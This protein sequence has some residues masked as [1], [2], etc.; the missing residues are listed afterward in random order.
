MKSVTFSFNSLP[1]QWQD[2]M[3]EREQMKARG[4][5]KKLKKN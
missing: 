3:E 1:L 4:K 2:R 5:R